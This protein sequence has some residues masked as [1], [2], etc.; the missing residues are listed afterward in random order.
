MLASPIK[1]NQRI[2][3]RPGLQQLRYDLVLQTAEGGGRPRLLARGTDGVD[4]DM[5]CEIHAG[6]RH[7]LER[8]TVAVCGQRTGDGSA[9]RSMPVVDHERTAS[10]FDDHLDQLDPCPVPGETDLGTLTTG[11]PPVGPSELF[12]LQAWP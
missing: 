9:R 8:A 7:R 5:G 10:A 12:S 3:M 1:I 6:P 2:R 11:P 4:S